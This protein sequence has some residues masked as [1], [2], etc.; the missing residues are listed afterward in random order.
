MVD[1]KILMQK[2]WKTSLGKKWHITCQQDFCA[3]IYFSAMS[4]TL[5]FI[6]GVLFVVVCTSTIFFLFRC[7]LKSKVTSKDIIKARM[8]HVIKMSQRKCRQKDFNF[9]KKSSL[10]HLGFAE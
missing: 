1:Y 4:S 5:L 3:K 10:L 7:H 6:K 2:N 8:S 9:S